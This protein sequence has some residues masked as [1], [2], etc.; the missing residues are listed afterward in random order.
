MNV[1]VEFNGEQHDQKETN[2]Q[3][4]HPAQVVVAVLCEIRGKTDDVVFDCVDVFI[5]ILGY[6]KLYMVANV[7]AKDSGSV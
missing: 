4:N 2:Q 7:A 6:S 1:C 3:T 5:H